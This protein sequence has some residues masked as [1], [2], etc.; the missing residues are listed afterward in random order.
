MEFLKEWWGAIVFLITTFVGAFGWLIRLEAQVRENTRE[1][2]RVW[3]Q[4]HEDMA[5]AQLSRA[6]TI[7]KIDQLDAKIEKFFSELR[8]ELRDLLRDRR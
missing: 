1:L 5:N 2:A 6:E 3:K 4:R 7:S 8:G